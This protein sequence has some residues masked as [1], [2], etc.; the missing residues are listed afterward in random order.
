MF[1]HTDDWG[2]DERVIHPEVEQII[3]KDQT[4]HKERTQ[5]IVRQLL[6]SSHISATRW[7]L[8]RETGY[9]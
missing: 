6:I 4:H 5:G 8:N 3:G 2:G 7:S 1:N 9:K